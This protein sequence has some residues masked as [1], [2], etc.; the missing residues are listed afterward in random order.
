MNNVSHKAAVKNYQKRLRERGL[1][2]FEVL[3]VA[4]IAK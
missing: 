1:S 3:G 2:R 4:R